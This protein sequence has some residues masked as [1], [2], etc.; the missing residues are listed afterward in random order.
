MT[1]NKIGSSKLRSLIESEVKSILKE[2]GQDELGAGINTGFD[3]V[4]KKDTSRIVNV[5]LDRV[6]EKFDSSL[7]LTSYM[8][9]A[10]RVIS[11]ELRKLGKSVTPDELL[12]LGEEASEAEM[13]LF[14]DFLNI[15][16]DYSSKIIKAYLDKD[17]D[18]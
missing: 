5:V 7:D 2:Y 17:N 1:T 6:R 11:V 3:D 13:E 9:I 16:E 8:N 15:I 4:V 12:L 18:L 14:M 10:S